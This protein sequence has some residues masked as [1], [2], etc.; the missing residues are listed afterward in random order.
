VKSWSRGDVYTFL[1]GGG[2]EGS[3]SVTKAFA[4]VDVIFKERNNRNTSPKC[5]TLLILGL[6]RRC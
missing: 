3:G 2:L 6:E 5:D 4:M 1:F